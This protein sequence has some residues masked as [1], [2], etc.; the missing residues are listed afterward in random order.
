MTLEELAAWH[1]RTAA[2]ERD[3]QLAAFHRRAAEYLRA[4]DATLADYLRAVNATLADA[5]KRQ[6]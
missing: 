1:D 6:S 5:K 2:I 3:D 4:M